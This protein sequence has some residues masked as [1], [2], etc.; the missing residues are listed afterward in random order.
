MLFVMASRRAGLHLVSGHM[1]CAGSDGPAKN[2]RNAE[3][4][5]ARMT[6]RARATRLRRY[7]ST[8]CLPNEFGRRWWGPGGQPPDPHPRRQSR[9]APREGGAVTADLLVEPHVGEVRHAL[10]RV[11]VD[12]LDLRAEDRVAL[13][14]VVG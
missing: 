11:V 13:V 4:S 6:L 8:F 2:S 3:T 10:V 9:A 1:A 14:V 5:V 12:V 7:V